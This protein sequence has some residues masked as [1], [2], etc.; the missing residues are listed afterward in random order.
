MRETPKTD[1]PIV[2][3]RKPVTTVANA[4]VVCQRVVR[5][6][7]DRRVYGGCDH[8]A[9]SACI[10]P[11]QLA[12]RNYCLQCPVPLT[13][14]D[15]RAANGYVIDAGNDADIRAS[16]A[17]ALEYRRNQVRDALVSAVRRGTPT[18]PVSS[19]PDSFRCRNSKRCTFACKCAG[20]AVHEHCRG[21]RW[22]A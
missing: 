11:L 3:E 18:R 1:I 16:V 13:N 21:A 19:L 6:N 5:S 17:A 8:V 15:A 9:H 12:G 4:C 14:D 2:V 10:L 22:P 7:D 20:R